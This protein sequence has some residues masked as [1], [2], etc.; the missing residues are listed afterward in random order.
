MAHVL[1]NLCLYSRC[2]TTHVI[3]I[4][5]KEEDSLMILAIDYTL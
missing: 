1:A 4:E 3:D 2:F 5:K